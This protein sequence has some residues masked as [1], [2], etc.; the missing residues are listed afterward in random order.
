M[1]S[2]VDE[3]VVA[4]EQ[5][6]CL[7]KELRNSKRALQIEGDK[8]S[9][10]NSRWQKACEDRRKLE[11]VLNEQQNL[12]RESHLDNTNDLGFVNILAGMKD[13]IQQLESQ[14]LQDRKNTDLLEA[15]LGL[16]ERCS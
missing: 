2:L 4:A 12:F 5:Y 11:G 3:L 15:E 7:A 14:I 16:I 1:G 13:I 8:H 10:T 9:T 6:D